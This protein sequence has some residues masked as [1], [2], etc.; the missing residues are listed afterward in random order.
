MRVIHTTMECM[1]H[2]GP[3]PTSCTASTGSS[4]LILHPKTSHAIAKGT[5]VAGDCHQ[6]NFSSTG[7]PY[8]RDL[9]GDE[10][11][12][13][14]L[15]ALVR[16]VVDDKQ[17]FSVVER[18]YFKKFFG[19]LCRQ[20][21][22]P[23]RRTLGRALFG[24]FEN[25]SAQFRSL[26]DGVSGRFGLTVDCWSSRVLEGYIVIAVHWISDDFCL[27]SAVLSFKYFPPLHNAISTSEIVMDIINEFNLSTLL[28]GITT[29][30][31]A[32]MPNAMRC[33]Q[34]LLNEQNIGSVQ[35]HWHILCK[36]HVINRAVKDAEVCER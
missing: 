9:M 18:S 25:A 31:G 8:R 28:I 26:I 24:E 1:S 29:D 32:E 3:N 21:T 7:R 33:L 5:G 14:V 4:A 20:Y 34:E 6:Q 36:C 13:E 12:A 17:S 2:N 23:S 35:E 19:A 11:R 16:W 15:K 30:S 22:L 27:Q 10:R